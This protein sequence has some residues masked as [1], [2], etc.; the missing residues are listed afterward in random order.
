MQTQSLSKES[1]TSKHMNK[2]STL[3]D[4]SKMEEQPAERTG[5]SGAGPLLPGLPNEKEKGRKR[6]EERRS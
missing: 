2:Q 6:A 1:S 5:Q 4:G 3:R